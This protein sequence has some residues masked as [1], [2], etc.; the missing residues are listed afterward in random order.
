MCPVKKHYFPD[1]LASRYGHTT[2][3]W[4]MRISTYDVGDFEGDYLNGGLG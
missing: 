1:S 4:S 3:F 2:M